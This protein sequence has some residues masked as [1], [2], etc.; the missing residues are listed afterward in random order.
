MQRKQRVHGKHLQNNPLKGACWCTALAYLT[1]MINVELRLVAD[2]VVMQIEFV[3]Q[4]RP[5]P[6]G[7][8]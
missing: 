1:K 7:E 2:V 6:N 8:G 5:S 3:I 4:H